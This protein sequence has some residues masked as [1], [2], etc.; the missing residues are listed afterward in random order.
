MSAN[1]GTGADRVGQPTGSYTPSSTNRNAFGGA[2]AGMSEARRAPAARADRPASAVPVV[3]AR[4]AVAAEDAG[5][6]ANH[7]ERGTYEIENV[8]YDQVCYDQRPHPG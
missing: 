2:G 3:A 6:Q 5:R 8:E 1:R 4:V 7:D